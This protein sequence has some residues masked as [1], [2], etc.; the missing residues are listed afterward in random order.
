M[1]NQRITSGECVDKYAS[2]VKQ[3]QKEYAPKYRNSHMIIPTDDMNWILEQ[4]PSV[5]KLWKECWVVDAYGSRWMQLNT[6]LKHSS[7]NQAKKI[8]EKQGLFIFKVDKSIRDGRE[9]VS[10]LVKNLHGSRVKE[11]WE[12][13]TAADYI[14]THADYISTHADY[15]STHADSISSQTLTQQGFHNLSVSSQ[16]HLSN[17]SKELLR[18]EE[19]ACK[20]SVAASLGDLQEENLVIVPASLNSEKLISHLE[21]AVRGEMPSEGVID[22]LRGSA[23]WGAFT[24]AARVHGWDL[25]E[26]YKSTMPPEIAE[27]KRLLEEKLKGRKSKSN[28]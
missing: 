4:K 13:S 24:Q 28:K 6:S 23:H 16:E 8:L 10:W 20:I 19:S 1:H 21:A 26:W 3:K 18:C 17:S 12:T 15:I 14:S 2:K 5:T 22:Q 25:T 11:Y 9:T 27:R 7:F